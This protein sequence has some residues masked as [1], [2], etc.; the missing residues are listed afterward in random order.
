[1]DGKIEIDFARTEFTSVPSK[2]HGNWWKSKKILNGN[3]SELFKNIKLRDNRRS[4]RFE[5]QFF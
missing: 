3:I 1:V 5:N 4:F 2:M